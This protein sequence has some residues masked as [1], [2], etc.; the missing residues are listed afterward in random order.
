VG[1]QQQIT[2]IDP[3]TQTMA[4]YRIDGAKGQIALCSERNFHY[5]LQMTDY[6]GTKPLSE[7]IRKSWTETGLTDRGR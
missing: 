5:D 1:D 7:D 2:I 4:V 3:E 6:C